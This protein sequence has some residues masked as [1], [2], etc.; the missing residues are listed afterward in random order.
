MTTSHLSDES[1]MAFADGELAPDARDAAERQ[2]KQD[3]D[4]AERADQFVESRVR[5]KRAL[6]PL[7]GEP[8]PAALTARVHA[9]LEDQ[10]DAPQTSGANVVRFDKAK[11]PRA[12]LAVARWAMPAAASVALFVGAAAGYIAGTWQIDEAPSGV[13]VAE[14]NQAGLAEA[15]YQVGAGEETAIGNGER[16]RVIATFKD[17]GD[18][19]CREFEVEQSGGAIVVAVACH[20]ARAWDV[21]FS[22]VAGQ[23]RSGYAPASSLESL[24]AYLGAVGAG[25]P[26]APEA[27]ADALRELR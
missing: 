27:E 9:M 3:K 17:A 20:P 6:A 7:L 10:V 24:N 18:T 15:L 8:V 1:L 22:V 11:R 21:Q 16:F 2:M 12:P 19:L 23:S 13:R 25:E 14:L 5:A 26:L 4:L